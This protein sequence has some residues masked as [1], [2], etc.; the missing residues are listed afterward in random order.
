MDKYSKHGIFITE[1]IYNYI[2]AH[3]LDDSK[4][5]DGY[6]TSIVKIFLNMGESIN[7][8]PHNSDTK[9]KLTTNAIYLYD[10]LSMNKKFI[11]TNPRFKD[12]VNKKLNELIIVTP[13]LSIYSD[14][15]FGKEN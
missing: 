5:Y 7:N 11:N 8:N 15:L 3:Q 10:F 12:A 2:G 9:C 13:Q 4:N 14:K 1:E 6:M